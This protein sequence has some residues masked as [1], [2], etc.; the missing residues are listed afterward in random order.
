L[1]DAY[2]HATNEGDRDAL[3][4]I[5]TAQFELVRGKHAVRGLDNVL[6]LERPEHVRTHLSLLEVMRDGES[7]VAT[8]EENVSWLDSDEPPDTRPV[9]ARFFFTGRLIGRVELLG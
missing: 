4:R 8:I 1:I 7:F 2:L 6:A 3:R 9:R 5:V